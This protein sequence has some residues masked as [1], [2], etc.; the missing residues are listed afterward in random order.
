M[1]GSDD[2]SLTGHPV[3]DLVARLLSDGGELTAEAATTLS[4]T[5][6]ALFLMAYAHGEESLMLP[7]DIRNERRRVA[8]EHAEKCLGLDRERAGT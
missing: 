4:E 1:T 2:P 5:F 8:Q 6:M 7:R 3:N